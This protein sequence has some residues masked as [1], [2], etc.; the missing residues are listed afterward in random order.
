MN[1]EEEK[2]YVDVMYV[3]YYFMQGA[4]FTLIFNCRKLFIICVE[5]FDFNRDRL[6][7]RP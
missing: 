3:L 6:K 5:Y 7:M 2:V 1:C 4:N